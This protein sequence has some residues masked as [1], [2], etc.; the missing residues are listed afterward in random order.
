M[1]HVP[2]YQNQRYRLWVTEENVRNGIRIIGLRVRDRFSHARH[3]PERVVFGVFVR[4]LEIYLRRHPDMDFNH[5]KNRARPLIY[6]PPTMRVFAQYM[7]GGFATYPAH[8][9]DV[10]CLH[11]GVHIDYL[12]R[13]LF[14]HSVDAIGLRS[15]AYA[16]SWYAL[17]H[18][19]AIKNRRVRWLSVAAGTGLPA[20]EAAELL[21]KQPNIVLSDIDPEALQFAQG[22]AKARGLGGRVR[23][24]ESNITEHG[25]FTELL[26]RTQPDVVDMMGLVEYLDN[27]TV[28]RLVRAFHRGAPHGSVLIF[29]NMRPTHPQLQIHERGLGWPG[30]IVRSIDDTL[31]LIA[32]AGIGSKMTEVLLPDDEVYAIYCI[33]R[34]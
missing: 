6:L 2:D 4:R 17:N 32:A 5:P 12:T 33:K 20:F 28:I 31:V 18:V 8:D 7:P 9:P 15:R 25:V 16:M 14:R 11:S 27:E 10:K 19:S 26:K 13:N 23:I 1:R 30:V 24:E 21:P 22:I 29:T 3:R 34:A